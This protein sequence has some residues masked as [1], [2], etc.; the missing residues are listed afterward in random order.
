[1]GVT[2]IV[3]AAG[4]SRRFG[5]PKQLFA[6]GGEALVRRAARS[7]LAVAPT[8]VVIPDMTSSFVALTTSIAIRE[9]LAGLGV[10]IVENPE[11]AEGMAS[12]I[13]VGVQACEGDVLI[14]VCDQPHVTSSHLAA[15]ITAGATI[16]ATSYDGTL[17]VPA[18]FSASFRQELLE[19]QGD[20]GAKALLERHADVVRAIPLSA[21]A[22]DFDKPSDV[23]P[24]Q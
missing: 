11:A 4:A 10:K 20:R 14:T 7:A 1:V 15:L 5:S 13:R 24:P 3:L 22:I 16:S 18:F 17:G 12:S 9:S 23:N 21:A 8:I 2:A 6:V 19:L